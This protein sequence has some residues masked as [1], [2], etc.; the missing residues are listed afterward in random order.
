MTQTLTI[1][2]LGHTGDGI[3]FL[4]RILA[5]AAAE[6][7]LHPTLFAEP[8][9]AMVGDRSAFRLVVGQ[10]PAMSPGQPDWLLLTRP[11]AHDWDTTNR[12]IDGDRAGNTA[13]QRIP[14]VQLATQAGFPKGA[15]MVILGAL[16]TQMA[17]L[18]EAVL[19]RAMKERLHAQPRLVSLNVACFR[20]G[21][22]AAKT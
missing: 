6:A 2:T 15:L 17:W 21:R 7:G 11:L 20:A 5:E 10:G 14:A 8:G 1:A 16:S 3:Q 22:N 4:G 19:V 12:L 13:G 9:V 18:T